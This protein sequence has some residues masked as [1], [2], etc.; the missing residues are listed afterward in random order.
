MTNKPT[1]AAT[2]QATLTAL[3]NQIHEDAW[4]ISAEADTASQYMGK[5]ELNTAMGCLLAAEAEIQ[6]IAALFETV[7]TL[8]RTLSH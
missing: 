1:S 6:R 8:H 7:R 4:R 2:A 5:G 3:Y